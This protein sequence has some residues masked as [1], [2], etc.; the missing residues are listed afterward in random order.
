MQLAGLVSVV[1]SGGVGQRSRCETKEINVVVAC[2]DGSWYVVDSLTD[3]P[4][5]VVVEGCRHS[6]REC[7][8]YVVARSGKYPRLESTPWNLLRPL[9]GHWVAGWT[10]SEYSFF[11]TQEDGSVE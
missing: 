1:V 10:D 2:R 3:I 9:E 8:E 5:C 11:T 7:H 6:F 4:R